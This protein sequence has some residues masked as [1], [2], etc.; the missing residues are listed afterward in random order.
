[1]ITKGSVQIMRELIEEHSANKRDKVS[2]LICKLAQTVIER[3]SYF[4]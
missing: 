1:M 3:C 4:T 2:K